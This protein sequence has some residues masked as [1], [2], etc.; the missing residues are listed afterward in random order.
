MDSFDGSSR[1]SVASRARP[2]ARRRAPSRVVARRRAPSRVVARRRAPFAAARARVPD[3]APRAD[4]SR[5]F[6][7]ARRFASR[8]SRAG[9]GS[10]MRRAW[11][12]TFGVYL[13]M[14]IQ[15]YTVYDHTRARI[16]FSAITPRDRGRLKSRRLKSRARCPR[17]R[18]RARRRRRHT[19]TR[20]LA[21]PRD[22]SAR[23]NVRAARGGRARRAKRR[24][25]AAMDARTRRRPAKTSGDARAR[26]RRR[27]ATTRDGDAIG[28]DARERGR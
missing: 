3:R 21:T 24:G 4:A 22:A 25:R 9:V 5:R 1:A 12:R 16:A 27:P 11:V 18:M 19:P 23:R 8:E 6:G 2:V 10:G 28:A 26:A 15:S 17:R 14:H 13:C 7:I 20:S